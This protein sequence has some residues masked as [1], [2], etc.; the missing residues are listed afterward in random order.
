MCLWEVSLFYSGQEGFVSVCMVKGSRP[1]VFVRVFL[2]WSLIVAED[3]HP[4]LRHHETLEERNY[5]MAFSK[6]WRIPRMSR[7][8][9]EMQ[10]HG[11]VVVFV[12]VVQCQ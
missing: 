8:T 7:S 12:V 3:T 1:C 5:R 6:G 9:R 2:R 10:L 11:R 4:G